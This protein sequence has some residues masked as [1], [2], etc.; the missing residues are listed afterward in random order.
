MKGKRGVF[1]QDWG[2]RCKFDFLG[3]QGY[4]GGLAKAGEEADLW[5]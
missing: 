5:K 3:V 2:I 4:E 1:G